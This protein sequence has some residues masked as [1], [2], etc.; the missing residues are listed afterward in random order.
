MQMNRTL[1]R[2]AAV[3][4]VSLA[5][6]WAQAQNLLDNGDLSNWSQGLFDED[7]P[8]NWTLNLNP[9]PPSRYPANSADFADHTTQNV[10]DSELGLWF[11]PT[12]GNYPGYPDVLTVDADLFQDVPG[13]E[14]Q[15][16]TL[17]AW[18]KFE[19]NYAGGVDTITT[20]DVWDGSRAG[21]PALTDTFLAL[22]FL[23]AGDSELGSVEV[24][25]RANGQVN[26]A[27]WKRHVLMGVAPAGTMEVRVRASMVDGEFNVDPGQAAFADD[28]LLLAVPEP[29][30]WSLCL[31]GTATIGLVRR[32]R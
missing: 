1:I 25:L 11:N 23:G 5:P 4:V 6:M 8:D 7:L 20:T 9:Y 22:E 10:L 24:E 17:A 26:G 21:L 2:L 31:L 3:A 19:Q 29:A 32:R 13:T 15:K 12:E 27:G 30:T 14:G 18:F 28:F 16:Y